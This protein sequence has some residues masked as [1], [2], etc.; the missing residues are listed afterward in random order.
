MD[1]EQLYD[2]L[3][4]I[5]EPK[6]YYFNNDK[7]KVFALLKGL[8]IN[9]DTIRLYVLPVQAG[10]RE[11]SNRIK[12]L[13]VPVYTA[14][15]TSKNMEAATAA[16]MFHPN[17]TKERCLI[18]T[19]LREDRR[20]RCLSERRL[21]DPEK[22]RVLLFLFFRQVVKDICIDDLFP[23][24][25]PDVRVFPAVIIPAPFGAVFPNRAHVCLP[26]EV[27]AVS[28]S[29]FRDKV[30]PLRI[31]SGNPLFHIFLRKRENEAAAD[32]LA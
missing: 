18:P 1:I 23:P 5:Q 16:S 30:G 21:L 2:A 19:F 26:V 24:V 29:I 31:P 22:I 15:R 7:E 12:T 4:K 13:S 14:R 10:F 3:K 11:L 17:G 8:L 9:K 6:G 27:G 28:V 20:R 32:S 25:V